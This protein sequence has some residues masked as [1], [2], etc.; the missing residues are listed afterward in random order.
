MNTNP[1]IVLRAISGAGKSTLA[2]ELART[3]V[4]PTDHGEEPMRYVI[5]STDDAF[6]DD[7]TGDYAFD[8]SKI[9]FAHGQCFRRAIE[10]IQRGHALIVDNTNCSVAEIAPYMLLA[11]AYSR[12]ARIITLR[13]DV[14]TAIE[15]A[16]HGATREAIETMHAELEAA[17]LLPWWEHEVR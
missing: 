1:V 4:V 9:G 5:V 17:V 10:A 8:A 12:P 16:T 6:T 7:E 3:L 13:C 11:Q 15:R 14:E 2:H